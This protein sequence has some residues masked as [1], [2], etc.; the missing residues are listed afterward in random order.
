MFW[1]Q[2]AAIIHF[3][4]EVGFL[5]GEMAAQNVLDYQEEIV[6]VICEVWNIAHLLFSTDNSTVHKSDSRKRKH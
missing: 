2:K 1:R 5:K 6:P 3:I 4:L